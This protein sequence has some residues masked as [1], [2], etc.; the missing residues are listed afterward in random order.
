MQCQMYWGYPAVKCKNNAVSKRAVKLMSGKKRII[1]MCAKCQ[2]KYFGKASRPTKRALDL[3]S[4]A[5][6]SAGLAQPANQ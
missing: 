2:N 4:G 1:G 5:A 3:L 6:K